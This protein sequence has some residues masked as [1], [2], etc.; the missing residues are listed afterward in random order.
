MTNENQE[1]FESYARGMGYSLERWQPNA[2][3]G[4]GGYVDD[5]TMVAHLAWERALQHAKEEGPSVSASEQEG[6]EDN[7]TH[8]GYICTMLGDKYSLYTGMAFKLWL[9][10]IRW[11]RRR[12]AKELK[13]QEGLRQERPGT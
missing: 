10:A 1:A 3:W 2:A 6:F 12:A 4:L 11:E 7:A 13:A 8:L 5:V 9:A